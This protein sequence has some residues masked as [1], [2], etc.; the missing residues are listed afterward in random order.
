MRAAPLQAAPIDGAEEAP[1]GAEEQPVD[2]GH[3]PAGQG[4]VLDALWTPLREALK[5]E[6][7]RLCQGL[8]EDVRRELRRGI[9][10]SKSSH[11]ELAAHAGHAGAGGLEQ[12]HDAV[13]AVTPYK[14]EKGVRSYR[15]KRYAETYRNLKCSMASE[16]EFLDHMVLFQV[17]D[18]ALQPSGF[19]RSSIEEDPPSPT[20]ASDSEAEHGSQEPGLRWVATTPERW[21]VQAPPPEAVTPPSTAG[22]ILQLETD[23]DGTGSAESGGHASLPGLLSPTTAANG[24]KEPGEGDT[25]KALALQP[26]GRWAAQCSAAEG[27]LGSRNSTGS[28]FSAPGSGAGNMRVQEQRSSQR[29][30]LGGGAASLRR[31]S[32]NGADKAMAL[33]P[34]QTVDFEKS[35]VLPYGQRMAQRIVRHPGF[36]AL[37]MA[38]ITASAVLIGVQTDV[39]ARNVVGIAPAPFR[40]LD[41]FFC[42]IFTIE[43]ALRIF[44]FRR[45]F[46]RMYGWVWNAFDTVLV[47]IQICEEILL[48]ISGDG[49]VT[50]E[51]SSWN[52]GF[53]LRIARVLRALR[54][55]RAL[56]F[57]RFTRELRLMMSCI[58]HSMKSFVWASA[59]LL[60]MI[61]IVSIYITQTVLVYRL[62]NTVG[63][64]ELASWFGSLP[65]SFLSLFQGLTGGVDWDDLVSPLIEHITPWCGVPFFLYILFA[66]FAVMNVVAALFVESAIQRAAQVKEIQ[67]VDQAM[68]LFRSLDMNESGRITFNDLNQRLES[69]EVVDLFKSIDVDVSE[70]RCL[71][72]MLDADNNG[73]IEFEEFLGGCM[74]LQGPAKAIDLVLVAREMRAAFQMQGALLRDALGEC[75]F[76]PSCDTDLQGCAR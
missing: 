18:P 53:L 27:R 51:V 19:S 60:I 13:H 7:G 14:A 20:A 40:G 63:E 74:R 52:T 21:P 24:E 48:A 66:T 70:A 47:V 10:D 6:L 11:G 76:K 15:Y 23:E 41:I 12:V 39:M 3:R 67:Q 46:L 29:S 1:E 68:R 4:A 75:A 26:G 55:I 16:D 34:A 58:V 65:R 61:Y 54:A 2:P 62:E 64:R 59:L 32:N 45:K 5:D 8:R 43:I 9:G 25:A 36:E 17:D 57:A 73:S 69:Q 56:H 71:F 38:M 33:A 42:V 28:A 31:S 72:E 37:V 50:Q 35:S 49:A 22:P 30:V 44:A